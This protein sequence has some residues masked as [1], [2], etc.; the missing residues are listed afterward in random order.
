[1]YPIKFLLKVGLD[2]KCHVQWIQKN[3]EGPAKPQP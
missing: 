2:K 1:M 3:P